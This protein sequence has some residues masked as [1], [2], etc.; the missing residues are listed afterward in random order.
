MK[1]DV[2]AIIAAIE[3]RARA[4]QMPIYKLCIAA[5]VSSTTVSHWKAGRFSPTVS[6]LNA[7]I[8]A[9]EEAEKMRR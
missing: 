1:I 2:A 4:I 6:T 3:A 5:G 7:V 8:E 9:L